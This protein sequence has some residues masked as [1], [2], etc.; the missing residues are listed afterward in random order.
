MRDAIAVAVDEIVP[1]CDQVV[2]AYV[3]S[4][5][6]VLLDIA[7]CVLYHNNVSY[8]VD[9]RRCQADES[10]IHCREVRPGE[11]EELL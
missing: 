10:M 1:S 2:L 8:Q 4:W 5:H 7:V 6:I 11:S 3:F 9:Y